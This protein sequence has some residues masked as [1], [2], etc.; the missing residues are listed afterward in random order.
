MAA[1]NQF[2]FNVSLLIY[3][4]QFIPANYLLAG[5]SSLGVLAYNS[6]LI[7]ILPKISNLAIMDILILIMR[8]CIALTLPLLIYSMEISAFSWTGASGLLGVAGLFLT[9][10]DFNS[11]QL[12]ALYLISISFLYSNFLHSE[13]LYLLTSLASYYLVGYNLVKD[14]TIAVCMAIFFI[15]LAVPLNSKIL[16]ILGCIVCFSKL[17]QLA[18]DI[19]KDSILF[20]VLLTAL[21]IAF[22]CTG[23]LYQ[24]YMGVITDAYLNFMPT[25]ILYLLSKRVTDLGDIWAFEFIREMKLLEVSPI[26]YLMSYPWSIILW[27][28]CLMHFLKSPYSPSLIK[29]SLILLI[30]M[31]VM[32][33]I[34]WKIQIYREKALKARLTEYYASYAVGTN[35]NGIIITIHGNKDPNLHG[36][37]MI[38]VDLIGSKFW[39]SI[40]NIFSSGVVIIARSAFLPFILTPHLVN[41]NDFI[42]GRTN[43]STQI[44]IGTGKGG[45]MKAKHTTIDSTLKRLSATEVD[46]VV[47]YSYGMFYPYCELFTIKVDC[48]FLLNKLRLRVNKAEES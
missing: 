22:V 35:E 27:P 25:P 23:L 10:L 34:S 2:D 43:F 12:I 7:P 37:K 17:T 46:V 44:E 30:V 11:G 1:A 21:G 8:T 36:I 38:A 9:K 26:T 42:K 45:T 13:M 24:Y 5:V 48:S 28:T 32:V 29:V 19:F 14:S 6:G 31:S 16:L 18:Y 20:P 3:S 15:F 47:L 40:S 33:F 39:E 4:V 41:A